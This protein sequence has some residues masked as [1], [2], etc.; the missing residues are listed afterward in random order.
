MR[1]RRRMSTRAWMSLGAALSA[2][3][4]VLSFQLVARALDVTGDPTPVT[5]NAT[6]FS[7][8]GAPYGGCGLPQAQLDTQNFLALNVFNTPGDYGG[9]TRP[10]PASAASTMGMFDNGLNCGRY[11]QVTVGDYCSGTNDGAQNEPFCRNGSWGPDAYNGATLTFVVADSCGDS[12]AWCRDDPYHVD[13][14]QGSLNQFA[15]NGKAVGD[16]YPNHWNNR[17]VS[18]QFV[19]APDYTGDINIGFLQSAQVYWPAIAVSHLPNGIHGIRYYS[20]GSWQGAR[21]NSD[22]GDDYIIAPTVAGGSQYQ[23]QVVD[24]SDNLLNGGR[25]YSFSLP[26]SCGSSCGQAYTAA[27]YTTSAPTSASPSTSASASAS[28]SPSASASG[29]AGTGACTVATSVVSSWTGGYQLQF[30]VTDSGT[31]AISA[32]KVGF[33]FAGAQ[34]IANSWNATV[35]QSGAAVS[36]TSAA[37]NGSLTPGTSTT[38]GMV[39]NGSDQ[40]LVDPVCG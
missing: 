10:I 20:A 23:I 21:M 7:S 38:W 30:T 33:S 9:F 2:F 31:S 11:V 19:P 14:A 35:T 28:A 4:L 36:A 12:N 6:W 13:L 37:Y 39:V 34:T 40:P 32:W 24:A 29:T 18:W 5:G 17:Q 1:A 8:L 22:M 15:L 3:A 16:M 27:T 26:A 25:I